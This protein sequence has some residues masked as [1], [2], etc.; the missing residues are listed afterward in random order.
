MK[1]NISI[2]SGSVGLAEF[3]HPVVRFA[4]DILNLREICQHSIL[5]GILRDRTLDD[6]LIY[7]PNDDKQNY[8]FCR[9]KLLGTTSL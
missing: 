9:L 3:Y 2:M 4:E 6:K 1:L 7:I 8:S 5:V